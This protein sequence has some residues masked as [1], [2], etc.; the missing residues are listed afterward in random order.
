MIF[1]LLWFIAGRLQTGLAKPK[2]NQAELYRCV[3]AAISPVGQRWW[4]KEQH[5]SPLGAT[6][7][8]SPS[9]A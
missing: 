7:E 4:A 6:P 2:Q 8:W 1:A 5:V 9:S 3:V